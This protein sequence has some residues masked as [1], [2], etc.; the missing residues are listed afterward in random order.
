M[1]MRRTKETRM[2][3]D[4]GNRND[5][6]RYLILMQFGINGFGTNVLNGFGTNVLQLIDFSG[7][8]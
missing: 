2:A 1:R 7:M 3:S 8:A 6:N 5:I 4:E